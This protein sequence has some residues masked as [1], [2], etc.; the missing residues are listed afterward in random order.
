MTRWQRTLRLGLGVF[1]VAFA[2]FVYFAIGRRAADSGQADSGRTDP[3]AITESR[4]GETL[5]NRG[6]TRD[7]S[8]K[9]DRLL[10]Y[11]DGSSRIERAEVAIPQ[12]SG[13]DYGLK[14]DS[15]RISSDQKRIDC[16][17]NV[18]LRS[19]DGL[20]VTARKAAY[21]SGE[22]LVRIPG[23]VGFRTG[24][25]E[26]RGVGATYDFE[27]EVLWLLDQA[28]ITTAPGDDRTPRTDVEAG[29]AGLAKRDRYFRFDRGVRIARGAQVMRADAAM[30][31]LAADVDRLEMIELRGSSR[32][33]G[34][35][36]EAGALQ[37]MTARDMNLTYGE[38]G[39]SLQRA[40]LA[41]DGV[42]QL[43][44]A[45]GQPGRR[46][47]AETM[48]MGFSPDGAR[49][50][51]L[52]AR[53]RVQLDLPAAAGGPSRR[54]RAVSLEA[55]GPP[56]TGLQSARF[57]D[58]VEFDET[59]PATKEREAIERSARSR[60]LDTAVTP[61]FGDL[62]AASFGGGVV[63]REGDLEATAPDAE[64]HVGKGSLRLQAKGTGAGARVDDASGTIEGRRIDLT[65]DGRGIAAS[66]DVR[67][68]MK[69]T[70]RRPRA[71][72][73]GQPTRRPALL[74]ADQ[75]VNITAG[76]LAYDSATGVATYSGDARLWQGETALQAETISLDEN[77]GN[78]AGAG[79]VR[80]TLRLEDS[81]EKG[82]AT[83]KTTV[84]TA[85]TMAY[86]DTL[87]RASYSGAARMNGPEGDLRGEHIELFLAETGQALD[88]IGAQEAVTLRTQSRTVI[89]ARLT[90]HASDGRYVM[91]GTPVR[92]LE[93]LSAECR[94]TLG[95]TLTFFR[96]VD[97]ITV[98]GDDVSRTQ[99]TSG[100]KC[101]EPPKTE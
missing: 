43:A 61:G 37:A 12:R 14:A 91:T 71:G 93:Q 50:H 94:E 36:S 87:R 81:G 101:P 35:G 75:P 30:A 23:P 63:F 32:V 84:L 96:S 15:A 53:D 3:K 31:Y 100:G 55:D 82:E 28:H 83:P 21:D 80:S 11:E 76:A 48:E 88:R 70:D 90:Y 27:R 33:T 41:G 77:K 40:V 46:L 62:Q 95:R 64:Y 2:V 66:G 92:A 58:A 56:E 26:G 60:T 85:K 47:S 67:S 98:D 57:L 6:E 34:E 18:E 89:G 54:I 10:T 29:A 72:G 19:D 59:T 52:V 79:A 45:S 13:R 44:G 69:G 51:L 5:A 38:D 86:D 22:G 24:K 97:T 25:L 8:V 49:V 99:T 73:G 1:A 17:G 4:K 74:K 42:V 78:L 65:L 7:F 68:R 16:E 20:V 39:A 9:Y